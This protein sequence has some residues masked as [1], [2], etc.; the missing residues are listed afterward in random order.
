KFNLPPS[1]MEHF[2][3]ATRDPAFFRLHKYMD[4][5]FKEH[6][7]SLPPYTAEEIGFPGIHVTGVSI[8][9]ELETFF[10]DFEFD[11][12]MAVDSS[13]AMA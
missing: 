1:V 6:K 7:D 11:L 12:K 8:E 2:E 13:E 3:T 10:E 4:N 9:G 5:I